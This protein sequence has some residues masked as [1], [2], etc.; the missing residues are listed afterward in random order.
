M[1]LQIYVSVA[2]ITFLYTTL[3]THIV[4]AEELGIPPSPPLQMEMRG[5]PVANGQTINGWSLGGLVP[6]QS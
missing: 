4:L 1:K 2:L 3:G 5:N 6:A